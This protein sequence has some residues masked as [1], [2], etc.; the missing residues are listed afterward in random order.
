MSYAE[1]PLS[2][3]KV[4]MYVCLPL[5]WW[6][7]PFLR[8]EFQLKS[9]KELGIIKSLRLETIRYD[10]ERSILEGAP[11]EDKALNGPSLDADPSSSG[12]I[13]QYQKALMAKKK[14]QLQ[15]FGE[16]RKYL[17][18]REQEYSQALTHVSQ[19]MEMVE[20]D[21]SKGT[22][23]ARNLLGAVVDSILMDEETVVHL[24]HLKEKHTV[25]YFHSLNVCILSLILG[26]NLGLS[27]S[28]LMELSL[29][30]LFHDIGKQRIP[31]KILLKKPPL[32]RAEEKFIQLHPRY[33]FSLLA[34]NPE[35]PS[36]VLQVIYQ[37]HERCN[38]K[39]YP[40]GVT[41]DDIA[42]FAKMT[43]VVDVYD[44]ICNQGAQGRPFTPHEALSY[45]YTHLQEDLSREMIS[46]F[47]KCLG[48]Y[49][50]GTLIELS[51]GSLGMVITTDR[52]QGMKPTVILYD[53]GVPREEPMIVNLAEDDFDIVRSLRPS[54]VRPE[55][56]NYLQPGRMVGFF[57]GSMPFARR[58]PK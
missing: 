41:G 8:N 5:S 3:V 20:V 40:E 32:T 53:E 23:T 47:I 50:P 22:T 56:I 55:V 43:T 44:N 9:E 46:V 17:V 51:D 38:G 10:P 42:P 28:E 6:K 49:P 48:V 11:F 24:L 16:R 58:I 54:E 27:R 29:G 30:A 2:D 31:K 7:H 25:S 12:S 18:K 19:I 21:P 52:A 36:R 26:R 14:R 37:H 4:G 1:I 13:D 34:R 39:G 15:F 33:G 45:L 35:I 57:A